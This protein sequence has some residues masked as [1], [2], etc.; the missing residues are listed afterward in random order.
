MSSSAEQLAQLLRQIY[1]AV[2]A[3]LLRPAGNLPAAE[4]AVQDAV[5]RALRHWPAEGLPENPEA[6]LVRAARNVITDQYRHKTVEQAHASAFLAMA[7][8]AP[9]TWSTPSRAWDD[10][11][12]R[13]IMTC[14]DPALEIH[15]QAAL[16]LATVV[17]LSQ[18][19]IANAFRVAPRAIEQRLV[20]ARKRLRARQGQYRSVEAREVSERIDATLQVI[21]LTFNEGYWSSVD[22]SVIRKDLCNLSEQLAASIFELLPTHPEVAGLLALLK[23]HRSRLPARLD[24][25]AFPIPLP[26]QDRRL[27]DVALIAEANALLQQALLQQTPGPFQVEAAISSLHCAAAEP[28]HTDWPQ[29]VMLYAKLEEFRPSPIVRLNRAFALSKA[30]GP[31]QGMKLLETMAEHP[32]MRDYPFFSLVQAELFEQL[33]R[34]KQA[35]RALQR[36]Y[37]L[38]RNEGE[39]RAIRK[40]MLKVP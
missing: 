23:L 4:D 8:T 20:R 18:M 3:K 11:M 13:L 40:R 34:N 22:G 2:L 36:A 1:P 31:E 37:G 15:E 12:L 6:W 26:E 32:A 10:E 25:Q 24:S 39:R 29:I 38:A 28:E 5:A 30:E 35:A 7:Q 17:G 27:W 21:H 33:G 14:C 16:T 9:W 19:E